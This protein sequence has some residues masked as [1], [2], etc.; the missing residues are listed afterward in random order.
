[1]T[2]PYKAVFKLSISVKVYSVNEHKPSGM[3]IVC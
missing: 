2:F 1:M 3:R